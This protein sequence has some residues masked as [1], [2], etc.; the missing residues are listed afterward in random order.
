MQ[1]AAQP[2]KVS[3]QHRVFAG[4]INGPGSIE[5]AVTCLAADTTLAK[6]VKMVSEAETRKSPTQRFTDRFERVFVPSVLALVAFLLF[7]WLV[8]DEPFRDRGSEEQS[9]E[10]QS[11][12]RTSNAFFRLKKK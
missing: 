3:A 7:A 12:M 6:V 9:S 11:L 4:T 2:D 10:F 5:I 8:I 1:A